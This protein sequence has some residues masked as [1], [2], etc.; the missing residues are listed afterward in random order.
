MIQRN[1]R[2]RQGRVKGKHLRDI[3]LQERRDKEFV[4]QDFKG[5]EAAAKTIQRV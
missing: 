2:G 1:E 4:A 5:V 3:Y